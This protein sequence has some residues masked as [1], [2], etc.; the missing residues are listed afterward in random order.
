MG[1]H[2]ILE[3]FI[4]LMCCERAFCDGHF[5]LLKVRQLLL[6][7]FDILLFS[8]PMLTGMVYKL[9]KDNRNQG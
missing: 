9:K 2:D 3:D 5:F 7:S 4:L 1:N 8:F 6:E